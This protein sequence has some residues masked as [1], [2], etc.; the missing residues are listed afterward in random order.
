[1]SEMARDA[2]A[3]SRE[4]AQRLCISEHTLRNHLTSIYSKLGLRSRMELYV[5]ANKHQLVAAGGVRPVPSAQSGPD[6]PQTA[7]KLRRVGTRARP[8]TGSAAR[9]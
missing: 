7:D 2:A 9:D 6:A 3:T 1:M 8:G 5:Y 4:I